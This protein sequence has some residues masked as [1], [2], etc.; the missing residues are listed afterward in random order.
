M[1]VPVP[2]KVIQVNIRP[3]QEVKSGDILFVLESM[4]MQFE[5][6]AGKDGKVASVLVGA[7]DQVTAGQQLGD[8]I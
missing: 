8:W 2:G 4:K 7:G 3:D 6:K 1:S 5:V